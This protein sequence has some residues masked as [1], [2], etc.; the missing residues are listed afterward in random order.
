MS[1]WFHSLM[2]VDLQQQEWQYMEFIPIQNGNTRV[3]K[4]KKLIYN[5]I[6]QINVIN[7]N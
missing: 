4:I 3:F 2:S 5:A 7:K 6:Y 1:N